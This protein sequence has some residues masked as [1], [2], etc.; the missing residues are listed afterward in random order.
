MKA[1]AVMWTALLAAFLASC[2]MQGGSMEGETTRAQVAIAFPSLSPAIQGLA[3]CGAEGRRSPGR[4]R[5]F[6]RA[7]R[8]EIR[9]LDSGGG[10]ADSSVLEP[11]STLGGEIY[12][13]FIV[14][15]G[16]YRLEAAIY[17]SACPGNSPVS[18]GS[19]GSF[20][21]E[22]G[23][24]SWI[25]FVCLPADPTPLAEGAESQPLDL[26][27]YVFDIANGIN[28]YREEKWFSYRAS[29]PTIIEA[30]PQDPARTGYYLAVYNARGVL[31]D[32][33]DGKMATAPDGTIVNAPD[34][35]RALSLALNQGELYYIGCVAYGASGTD[36]QPSVLPAIFTIS[37]RPNL[38][39]S[40]A[41]SGGSADYY[42]SALDCRNNALT[43][44]GGSTVTI[45]AA[46]R[47]SGESLSVDG[48]PAAFG[49]PVLVEIDEGKGC[50]EVVATDEQG[51]ADTHRVWIARATELV[52]GTQAVGRSLR[53]ED[54]FFFMPAV[55]STSYVAMWSGA[56][57]G[58]GF[59]LRTRLSAS[60]EDAHWYFSNAASPTS[61][62]FM[63]TGNAS[64]LIIRARGSEP[65]F[66]G[67]LGL[68][69]AK[70]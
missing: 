23:Q 37:A 40:L 7:S 15:P 45:T 42:P 38:F 17:N 46:N 54:I 29:G 2:G 62:G 50:V 27:P 12:T 58:G 41:V 67:T 5:P 18:S 20:T 10:L 4:A 22:A 70:E 14:E 35:G 24:T 49:S 32:K 59:S 48:A 44:L 69:V 1:L 21:V 55:P 61:R 26:N 43:L 53:G 8:I 33:L 68:T 56:D 3:D 25:S 11:D 34:G 6:F 9:L 65:G 64:R 51:H 47:Y 19:S 66:G 39:A 31:I 36:T 52:A 57:S 60:D 63:T 28:D 13:N 16:S 30:K